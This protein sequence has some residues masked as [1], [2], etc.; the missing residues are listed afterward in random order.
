METKEFKKKFDYNIVYQGAEDSSFVN[1]NE[2]ELI[3]YVIDKLS[4]SDLKV[5]DVCKTSG[6]VLEITINDVANNELTFVAKM[7]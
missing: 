1:D 2:D 6:D 4:K 3:G 7:K 5:E